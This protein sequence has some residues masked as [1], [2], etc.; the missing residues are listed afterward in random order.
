MD[1]QGAKIK[2]IVSFLYFSIIGLLIFL[3]VKFLLG[4]LIPFIVAFIIVTMSRKIISPLEAHL[5]SKK[6]VAIAF[7]I[8]FALVLSIIVYGI[9][10]GIFYELYRLSSSITESSLNE[11]TER[12]TSKLS[13][14]LDS[15]IF[16]NL[17]AFLSEIFKDSRVNVSSLVSGIAPGL[18]SL[19]MKFLSFFPTAVIF[20]CIMFISMYYIGYDYEKICSFIL[21]QIPSKARE[22]L[23]ET[24]LVFISTAKELF[25]SYFLLTFITFLQLLIGFTIIGIDYAL[26]LASIICFIDLLPILGT[27]TILLPWAG[28][29]FLFENYRTAIG[30]IVL[31]AV[32]A[33]FRQIAEPRI[34]GANTGLSP[35]VSL[36]SIFVGI[37]LMGFIGII[38]FPIVAMTVIRLNE[39]GFIKLYNNFPENTGDKIRKTKLKFLNFKQN[40]RQ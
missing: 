38:V 21:M 35:L 7:T 2:F 10:Y 22:T 39:K 11:F 16:R 15:R 5:R 8:L 20:I 25:K 33:L 3:V 36:I 6:A 29:S 12:L 24:K 18:L 37:K 30:L 28:I 34:V 1:S 40:D 32:I 31:Y 17:S 23:D 27:G 26:I 13:I 4:P 9:F 14:I 19:I